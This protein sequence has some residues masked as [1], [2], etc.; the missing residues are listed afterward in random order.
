MYTKQQ[1]P[2]YARRLL[3][4]LSILGL[5]LLLLTGCMVPGGYN[6]NTLH[7]LPE[8]SLVYPGSTSI[9]TNNYG[10]SPWN[11][12]GKGAAAA[13]GKLAA[14]T[15]TGLEVLAYFSKFLAADRWVKTGED[16]QGMTAEGIPSKSIAWGKDSLH[17]TYTVEVW[18]VGETTQYRTRLS[19]DE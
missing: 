12:I 17:L 10:G 15:H 9:H 7:L 19:P 11:Y 16:D 3:S 5:S 8:S 18:T 13:T 14:T 1:A 4:G 2:K 6:V